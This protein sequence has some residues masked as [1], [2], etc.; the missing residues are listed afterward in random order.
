MTFEKKLTI[1]GTVLFVLACLMLITM[2]LKPAGFSYRFTVIAITAGVVGIVLLTSVPP[3][4]SRRSAE[5]SADEI[6][7]EVGAVQKFIREKTRKQ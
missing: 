2:I 6:E 3:T 4:G 1:A 7:R 5:L